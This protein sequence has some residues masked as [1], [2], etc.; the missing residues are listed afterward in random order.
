MLSIWM[1]LPL[2]FFL[3]CEL[4]ASFRFW[5]GNIFKLSNFWNV[6]RCLIQSMIEEKQEI[7]S[8]PAS[9]FFEAPIYALNVFGH[10]FTD[11]WFRFIF[12]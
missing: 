4:I 6:F 3:W 2:G 7:Y 9:N 8:I 1:L 11:I 12:A 10:L 5:A